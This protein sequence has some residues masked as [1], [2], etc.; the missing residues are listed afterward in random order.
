MSDDRTYIPGSLSRRAVLVMSLLAA[1]LTL[2][3]L[4]R[5]FAHL[6]VL[7]LLTELVTAVGIFVAAG[8]FGHFALRRLMPAAAP[9]ALRLATACLAGLWMLATAVLMVGSATRGLLKPW[10][11]W[12]VLGIGLG[13]AIWAGR[14]KVNAWRPAKHFDGRVLVCVVL[15][16]AAAIWFAGASRPPGYVGAAD[17]YDVLEYH[18]QVPR[19]FH[20]AQQVGQLTHNCYS[21]YPLGV[22][23][24]FLL[25]MSLRGGAYE[26]MY[27]AKLLHGLFG[28][29]AVAS[30]FATLK[31][32]DDARGRFSAVL[33]ASVPFVLYLSW[34]AMVELAVICCLAVAV[35]WLRQWIVDRSAQ[36]ACCIG[37][38]L[39][40]ACAV[41]Y[42]S[43][44]F[45]VVPVAAVMLVLSLRSLRRLTHLPIVALAT[46]LLFSPWLIR[47][48]AYTGNPVFPLATH[49]FDPGHWTA[50][51]QQR[52]SD[53]HAP[54][55]RPPV[56][57]PDGWKSRPTVTRP[58]M[59]Y[60]HFLSSQ[61]FG[62]LLLLIAGVGLCVMIADTK[63]PD[64]WDW[65]LV[66]VGV[67]QLALWTAATRDMPGRFIVPIVV[68][69]V[70][71][72]GGALARLAAVPTNPFRKPIGQGGPALWGRT[73]A[74]V[75][76]LVVVAINLMTSVVILR[77]T[78]GPPVPPFPGSEIAAKV[79]PFHAAAALPEGSKLMLVGQAR[80][81]Y[82]PP[83]TIYATVFD[84]HPLAEMLAG[85]PSAKQTLA[86]LRTLG[87]T[88]IWMDW[89]EISRLANTYGFPA[90]LTSDLLERIRSGGP[91]GTTNL[92][93]LG[94]R[95]VE[96]LHRPGSTSRP[97]TTPASRPADWPYATLY[98]L[99]STR[100]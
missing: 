64:P 42:L 96:N 77:D 87:V 40:A 21:Y 8:G 68:P 14:K 33:L 41:K 24:L 93:R 66:G 9:A 76:F 55:A 67:V 23:M 58:E 22:E 28:V 78:G 13:L 75:V 38:M 71:L 53:G 37:L 48:A 90:P 26:G 35:L 81:F 89:L 63:R 100:S 17:A 5:R 20:D 61:W 4:K 27:M 70:L 50:E 59:L 99:P 32:D 85:G 45:V 3:Y 12:P 91:V 86:G 98:A 82:F 97:A 73:P 84:V 79:S 54:G 72:A 52:F 51:S 18:L 2:L 34:L 1:A 94:L 65:S 69:V 49:I 56:P 31:P 80:A 62:P 29:L 39:G 11:W 47:N 43:V 44:G 15:A 36:S 30:V 95:T 46:L 10:F 19:E 60:Y 16:T 83:G 57:V 6:V 25:G 74:V 92:D 7:S 88:H